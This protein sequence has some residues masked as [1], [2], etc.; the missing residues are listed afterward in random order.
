[1]WAGDDAE[2]GMKTNEYLEK[3]GAT[4]VAEGYVVDG[5]LVTAD[6]PAH[7]KNFAE[8]IAKLLG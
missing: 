1:M 8:E 5:N 2:F 4:Y 7:A 3:M 6:G